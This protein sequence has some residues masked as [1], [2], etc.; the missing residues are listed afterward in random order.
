MIPVMNLESIGVTYEQWMRACN[1][2]EAQAVESDDVLDVQRNAAEHERWDLVYN[3]SLIAGLETSVLIDANGQIQIDWGSPGRVPLRPPV[4]MMAPF[5]VWVHTHPGFHAYWSGTD[6][7]SL[8]IAQGILS[9]ALVLGAPGIKRSR[10]LGPDKGHS[11]GLEG[12]LQH[13]TE[14]DIT[15]WDRWYAEHKETPIEVMV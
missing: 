11:I 6:K 12:P 14:E 7:N 2:A 3:L 8:A 10:N 1:Q 13:W 5:R 15:P 9:S 4:G